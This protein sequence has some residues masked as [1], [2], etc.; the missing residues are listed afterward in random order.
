MFNLNKANREGL[1]WIGVLFL[2]ILGLMMFRDT[3]MY[4]PRPIMVTP[5]REGSIFDLENKVECTPG[6]KDGSAY[7]KSLT[8]GGLC[9]AQKLVSDLS[10]YE[11]TDG[12]GGSLI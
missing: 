3:S 4:Q 8:P 9:G 7:T 1:K 10:S 5:I 2:I 6:N 11:I 12:I